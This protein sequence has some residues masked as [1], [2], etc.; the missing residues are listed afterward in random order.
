MGVRTTVRGRSN[1]HWSA[2]LAEGLTLGVLIVIFIFP[3]IWMLSYSLRETG[4]PPANH[5]ELFEP[6]LEFGNYAA[7]E[8]YVPVVEFL[9]NSLKVVVIAVPLTLL[10]ASWAGL[11]MTQVAPR[12][13]TILVVMS[14][15]LMLIP[16]LTL[17]VP[18]F[19]IF[20][21]LRVL[22][23]Y[24]PLIA[25]GIMGTTPF[26]I[27]LFFVAFRRIT[28]EIFDSA[29]LDGAN[30]FQIWYY[31]A[32]PLARPAL[33]AVALLAFTFYW[34]DYI[35]PLL[36]LRTQSHYTFPVAIQLLQQAHKSNFPILMAA[37]TILVAPIIF[38]FA[39]AQRYFLQG[40]I[41]LG[42][43]IGRG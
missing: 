38:L 5:F 11:A 30:A 29:R 35:A 28:S 9:L 1:K 17:W 3:V 24:I 31:I 33:I 36:Y 39:F 34:S 2:R 25:P 22:D 37:S 14:V 43:W 18:R 16:A 21:Q 7:V 32:L 13:R 8:T 23:T 42:Q 26:Y 19:V 40:Q 15:A 27:L 10:T 20:S 12:F 6:P 4:L 41:A